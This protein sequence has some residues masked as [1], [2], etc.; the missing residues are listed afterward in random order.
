MANYS[1]R[2]VFKQFGKKIFGS[3]VNSCVSESQNL[4]LAASQGKVLQDQITQLNSNIGNMQTIA[5]PKGNKKGW[6]KLFSYQYG[7]WNWMNML[8]IFSHN[9][10]IDLLLSNVRTDSTYIDKNETKIIALTNFN[11]QIS[12]KYDFGAKID[13]SKITF[14]FFV[15]TPT[16]D[17]Y[18]TM[19]LST[20]TINNY[21][22]TPEFEYVGDDIQLDI[23]P[24]TI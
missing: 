1:L 13:G 11:Q 8:M 16:A 9:F 24:S 4:P 18:I 23:T 3:C 22:I 19:F 14:Y 17:N 2:E 5:I 7:T 10:S 6:Y 15:N 20:E 21:R 12:V